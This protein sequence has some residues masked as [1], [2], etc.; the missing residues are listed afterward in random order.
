[1]DTLVFAGGI[2]ENDADVRERICAGLDF[3]GIT[4]DA[5]Q[6]KANA[7]VISPAHG[8]PATVRIIHTNEESVMA[9]AAWRLVS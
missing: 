4:I 8:G 6:N 7:P 1:V 5:A 2:G 9:K 3:L